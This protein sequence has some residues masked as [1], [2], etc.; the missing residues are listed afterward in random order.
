V[1]HGFFKRL[2]AGLMY[3]FGYNCRYGNW[4]EF[5]LSPDHADKLRE[6]SEMLEK[7]KK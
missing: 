1:K 5:V 7:H 2:K 4:E 3:I 6:L